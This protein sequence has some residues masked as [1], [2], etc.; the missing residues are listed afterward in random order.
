MISDIWQKLAGQDKPIVLYGMGNGADKILS[1]FERYGIKASGIFASDGFVR[2]KYFHG[3]R[4]DSYSGIC[5]K[6][7]DFTV[8]VSFA[9]HLPEVIEN[10]NRIS[11]EREL[12]I[13][14]VPVVADAE[15]FNIEFY[16]KNKSEISKARELFSDEYSK[17]LFD[18]IIEYRLWGQAEALFRLT[19]KPEEVFGKIIHPEKIKRYAD[20]GAYTGDTIR[21]LQNFGAELEYVLALEPDKRSYK[22]LI[23]N[24]KNIKLFDAR[25]EGAW[26]EKCVL[27][28]N[29]GLGRGSVLGNGNERI[30]MCDIDSALDGM[31]VDYIKYDVEG[32]EERSLLG[33]KKTICEY[34]PCLCVSL[35]HR[36]EDIFKIPILISKMQNEYSFYLRR[37]CC[38]PAWDLNLYAV[39]RGD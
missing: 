4:L 10:V 18:S 27:E 25:N 9:S 20:A 28:F 14:E 2:D 5:E 13:P 33:S 26:S 21:E 32:C 29:G 39:K 35:Y 31:P 17:A 23:E 3:M 16:E 8:V 37:F 15:L 6:F 22:K 12:V 24:T 34:A 19:C 30:A 36:S 38:M 11:H 1:V 7:S